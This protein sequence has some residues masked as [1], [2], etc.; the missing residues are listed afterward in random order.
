MKTNQIGAVENPGAPGAGRVY[1]PYHQ[2]VLAIVAT[3]KPNAAHAETHLRP[4]GIARPR[5]VARVTNTA[6][7]RG[8]SEYVQHPTALT[9]ATPFVG[10]TAMTR[11]AAHDAKTATAIQV[12][13]VAT[14]SRSNRG[15]ENRGWAQ[16]HSGHTDSGASPCRGYPHDSHAADGRDHPASPCSLRLLSTWG[17]LMYGPNPAISTID[18]TPSIDTRRDD[19]RG[20]PSTPC[21]AAE[22]RT[23]RAAR[24]QSPSGPETI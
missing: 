20:Y 16:P 6:T 18:G 1:V 3:A 23:L 15:S 5:A 12:A 19:A 2:K 7:T 17:S 13:R 11:N 4:D 9:N 10:T 22:P 14:P 21:L 24:C 8:R